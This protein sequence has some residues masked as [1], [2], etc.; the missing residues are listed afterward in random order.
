MKKISMLLMAL[1][2]GLAAYAEDIKEVVLTTTPQMHCASCETRIK[3]ALKFERGMVRIQTNVEKQTVT[4][5]YDA[6][7]VAL[8]RILQLLKEAGYEAKVVDPKAQ[9]AQGG[10][11]GGQSQEGNGGNAGGC[12]G[13]KAE[14]QQTGGGCC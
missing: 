4:V 2:I 7:R 9:S 11:C 13:G 1:F 10:C 8:P 5:R 6:E 12:C 3:N 14:G